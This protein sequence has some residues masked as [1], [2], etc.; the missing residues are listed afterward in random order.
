MLIVR[1]RIHIIKRTED[2]TPNIST[3]I[4]STDKG[5]LYNF[6]SFV[7]D[8]TKTGLTSTLVYRVYKIASDLTTFHLDVTVLKSKL[9]LNG[10]PMHLISLG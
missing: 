1:L 8:R 3:R 7:P 10:F 2:P 9:K 5:L 4:K 6:S